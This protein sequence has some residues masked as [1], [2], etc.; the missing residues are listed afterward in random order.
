MYLWNFKA[1]LLQLCSQFCSVKLAITS[2]GLDD[3]ALLLDSEV[4][5]FEFWSDVLLEQSKDLV[6]GDSSWVCKVVDTSVVVLGQKDGG[7][8]EVGEE[9]IGLNNTLVFNG[10]QRQSE[11]TYVWNVNDFVVFRNLGNK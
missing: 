7:R 9:G 6:V 11:G 5:P 10:E 4:A 3:L 1:I 8:K 2:A